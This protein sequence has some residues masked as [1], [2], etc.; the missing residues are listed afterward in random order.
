MNKLN[1]MKCQKSLYLN[2]QFCL[3]IYQ[4]T[5]DSQLEKPINEESCIDS[6]KD[7]LA[8]T[9]NLKLVVCGF[10]KQF[11][12][13]Q[14]PNQIKKIIASYIFFNFL[15]SIYVLN[16]NDNTIE[17]YEILDNKISKIHSSAIRLNDSLDYKVYNNCMF[18]GNASIYH[19]DED[20]IIE[21]KVNKKFKWYFK[22]SFGEYLIDT[23]GT[24]AF[25]ILEGKIV[26]SDIEIFGISLNSICSL[27]D[28]YICYKP[29]ASVPS[30]SIKYS[31]KLFLKYHL[32]FLLTFFSIILSSSK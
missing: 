27:N 23:D 3:P 24:E 31:P 21:K 7:I 10:S 12:H 17:K 32:N 9:E 5:A 6:K 20:K 16:D 2:Q 15:K 11:C 22:N 4:E 29:K 25:D 19:F 8:N 13:E 18:F 14:I 30:V 26:D 28:K 1:L